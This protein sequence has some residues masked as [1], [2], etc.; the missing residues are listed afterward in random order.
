MK[1][2]LIAVNSKFIHS[3]LSVWYLKSV[4]GQALGEVKVLEYTINDKQD[5]VLA[6]IYNEKADIAAFSCYI[7]N[8]EYVCDIIVNLKALLPE[9]KI[10]LGGPEV[11]YNSYSLM[12]KIAAIDYIITGE[13]E[14]AFRLLLKHIRKSLITQGENNKIE[15]ADELNTKDC[16]ILNDIPGLFFRV[17][18]QIFNNNCFNLVQNLDSI[19][20]PYTDEML[21]NLGSNRIIYFESSRGCP[22]SCSYCISSTFDG[23]RYFS[24]DRTKK[25][26]L[27]LLD[28]KVKQIK[29]V[30]RTF[31][32]N[33]ERAGELLTF[34][35]EKARDTNF[36]FEVA[37]DLFDDKIMNILNKAPKG[38][39]QLEIGI[40]TVNLRTLELIERKTDLAKLFN[41]I[42]KLISLGTMHIHVDL[43]AGLPEEDYKSFQESFNKVYALKPHQLQLGFLKLLKGSKMRREA[44]MYSY[45]YKQK[46]PYE[47]F[48][49]KFIS[50]D[51]IIKLKDIEEI[52]ER[53]FNSGKFQ[54]SLDYSMKV[55][56]MSP[57]V[58]FSALSYYWKENG[59][60]AR[61]IS[62]RE[63]YSILYT[64]L[65]EY[66]MVN[67][68]KAEEI[69][70]FDFLSSDSTNNLP[71]G[72]SH[73]K[74]VIR[75]EDVFEFLRLESNIQ[76][77]LPHFKGIPS[78]QILKKIHVEIFNFDVTDNELPSGKTTVLFDYSSRDKVSGLYS[79]QR[80]PL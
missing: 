40:Q 12:E 7:W 65:R 55:L 56:N 52:V 50:Y 5:S 79:Y 74:E 68:I 26:I 51:E 66:S 1:T 73:N 46:A 20:S 14:N 21:S 32:C 75:N 76:F 8:I 34:I 24:L 31:N 22:F 10:V 72:I 54:K 9:I 62:S 25:D 2:L 35:I 23:V 64:F 29:F 78:K 60:Y 18:N 15:G 69:L 16:N 17:D 58:F 6:S 70:K 45:L 38:L 48:C 42:N 19:P 57:F 47:I 3:S 49:N 30:D 33:R 44:D 61:S 36:H 27:R 59:L 71:E 67:I 43:I 13:G 37:G 28:A 53:Y 80:I 11:S 77:Y 63:L 41:N 39:I 4:C